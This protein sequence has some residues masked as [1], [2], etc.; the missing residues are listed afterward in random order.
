M[1]GHITMALRETL[2]E[3]RERLTHGF[4][5]QEVRSLFQ[6]IGEA[7]RMG[8]DSSRALAMLLID[9]TLDG[10]EVSLH[11]AS[12]EL[13]LLYRALTRL[14]RSNE[15]ETVEDRGRVLAFLDAVAWGLERTLALGALAE[16]ELDS[17]AHQFLKVVTEQPGLTNGE[18]AQAVGISDNEASRVGRRLADAGLAAKR[19]LGR[20]NHWEITPKGLQTVVLLENGALR[21]RR[22]HYQLH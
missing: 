19:R 13:Q 7:G 21:Y 2:D 9:A 15:P 8:D 17:S 18:V 6:E 14:D 20:R 10:D 1:K 3:R 4:R 5:V 16:I 22:P 11:S 12:R